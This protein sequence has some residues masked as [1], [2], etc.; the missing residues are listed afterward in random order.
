MASDNESG[1]RR[2]VQPITMQRLCDA[3][4]RYASAYHAQ[5][6]YALDP[7]VRQE[8]SEAGADI[9]ALMADVVSV[10]ERATAAGVVVVG[11]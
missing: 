9:T 1:E 8:Y 3:I 2:D 4:N 10:V 7:D 11:K 5:Q 6:R